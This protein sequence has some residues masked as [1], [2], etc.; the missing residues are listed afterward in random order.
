MLSFACLRTGDGIT[1]YSTEEA[2]VPLALVVITTVLNL[3]QAYLHGTVRHMTRPRP[4]S[5][6]RRSSIFSALS[7]ASPAQRI[8]IALILTLAGA[9]LAAFGRGRSA[10]VGRGLQV[11]PDFDLKSRKAGTTRGQAWHCCVSLTHC[12]SAGFVSFRS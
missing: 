10:A 4:R 7:Y 9:L 8:V 3:L 2:A 12:H 11:R 6:G 5:S 1:E